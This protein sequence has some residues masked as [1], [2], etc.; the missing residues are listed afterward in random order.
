MRKGN[1]K[2]EKTKAK[3]IKKTKGKHKKKMLRVLVYVVLVAF[4]LSIIFLIGFGIY[5]FRTSPKYNLIY[6][7]Y[8]ESSKYDEQV[9]NEA[10]KIA[11]GENIFKIS[12]K[13]ITN[14]LKE[15]A[16]IKDVNISRKLPD[17][18]KITLTEY[19]SKYFAYNLEEN[20]YYRLNE[21]GIIL[22]RASGE[23]KTQEEL[24]VFGIFFDDDVV[25]KEKIA[26]TEIQKLQKFEDILKI[27]NEK[28]IEN[29]VTNIEFKDS[30][31]I[32]TLDYE[33]N[34]ILNSE[35]VEYNIMFLKNILNNLTSKAGTIDMTKPNPVF[36]SNIR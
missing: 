35:N 4:M 34:V 1:L 7:E 36:T 14:N 3:N 30:N 10:S 26:L 18:L 25:L 24:L 15:L 20:I 19:T 23:E 2:E 33:L 8:L 13:E 16:Y 29:Q 11:L 28:K 5:H 22:E 17:T 6:V 21:E 12:K 32:L 31:I 9:L 27:Y